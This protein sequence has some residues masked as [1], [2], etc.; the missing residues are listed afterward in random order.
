LSR[1]KNIESAFQIT[2]KTKY[3]LFGIIIAVAI[4]IIFIHIIL[5]I[6]NDFRYIG[7][8]SAVLLGSASC[9]LIFTIISNPRNIEVQKFKLLFAGLTLWFLGEF[10]YSY[11]QI[12]LDTDAPYPGV[13]EIFYLAGFGPLILFTYRS[14]KTINRETPIY[15][16]LPHYFGITNLFIY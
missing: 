2:Y 13:G 11:Y 9:L 10:S 3:L 12:V 8:T 7:T 4:A 1:T 6:T 15:V 5:Y 14:F 16:F